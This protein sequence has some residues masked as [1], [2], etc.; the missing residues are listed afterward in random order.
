VV[1]TGGSYGIGKAFGLELAKYGFNLVIIARNQERMTQTKEEII[2]LYPECKITTIEADFAN[3]YDNDLFDKIDE[4]LKDIDVSILINNV[5][6]IENMFYH[7]AKLSRIKEIIVIN[8]YSQAMLTRKLIKR[9]AARRTLNFKS[10]IINVSSAESV[11]PLPYLALYSA[12]KAFNDFFSRALA[13]EFKDSID[14]L[15]IRPFKVTQS[16]V[17]INLKGLLTITPQEQRCVI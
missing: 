8:C 4:Q 7:E 10:A 13:A 15:S 2:K 5:G 9:L 11:Y 14:I 3:G 6:Q 12:T 1:I 16:T 17:A